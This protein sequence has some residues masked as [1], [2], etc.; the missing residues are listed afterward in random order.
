MTVDKK[1]INNQKVEDTED[2]D[3]FAKALLNKKTE[4]AL[5]AEEE[6]MTSQS[7]DNKQRKAAEE[8]MSSALDLLRKERGQVS[9]EEEEEAY[10]YDQNKD[11]FD[12]SNIGK[13][14]TFESIFNSMDSQAAQKLKEEQEK[15]KEQEEAL[16]EEENP[17]KKKGKKEKKEKSKPVSSKEVKKQKQKRYAIAAAIC[18]VLLLLSGYAYKVAVYD[19]AHVITEAQ[20]KSYDK[21]VSYADEWDMLSDAEKLEILDL[22]DEYNDLIEPQKE[23]INSYFV[24]QTDKKFTSLLK[25]MKKLS[26]DQKDEKNENYIAIMNYIT[27][28]SSRSDADKKLILN[29]QATYDQL[30]KYLKG[31]INDKCVEETGNT[32]ISLCKDQKDIVDSEK[33]KEQL[34]QEEDRKQKILELQN[35]LNQLKYELNE[36]QVYQQSLEQDLMLGEEVEDMI[37]TNKQS[38]QVK[39]FE[40]QQVENQIA[41]LEQ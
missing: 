4:M 37:A 17:K 36:L 9:I 21:L 31:K 3:A 25:Q 28:W 39:Q 6:E 26:K 18:F 5:F 16:Q 38:I 34:K 30:S 20:Q 2:L 33:E 32:F 29:Y 24:E 13:N 8:T 12:T 41:A 7:L 14:V 10:V 27:G 22:E 23:K 35:Q 1:N 19:P 40:I 15:E 11:L